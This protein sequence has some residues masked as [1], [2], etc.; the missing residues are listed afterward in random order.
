[1]ENI[2]VTKKIQNPWRDLI[3]SEKILS[4]D[5]EKI[6]SYNEKY[7]GKKER[8][9]STFDFPE[10]FIGTP[11]ADVYVLLANPGRNIKKEEE[12]LKLVKE[13]GLERRILQ[14]LSHD[15]SNNEFPFYFLDP[16]FDE[17]PG[18]KWWQNAFKKL[19]KGDLERRKVIAN[20]FFGIELFGYHSTKCE[21]SL[22]YNSQYRLSSSEYSYHLVLN[23]ITENKIIILARAVGDW[24]SKV[25][26]LREYRNCY[27]LASNRGIQFSNRTIS[28]G[29]YTE[30]EQ[31]I[32][33]RISNISKSDAQQKI[34]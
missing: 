9:V 17:H 27:F 2:I 5:K 18:G 20:E 13:K 4:I 3:N 28:P 19:I 14:N 10:P 24:F 16:D 33:D 32:Q 1:M 26:E 34:Q 29:A 11:E 12:L 22:L 6:E 15:F 8:Q 21:R 23:A 30:I 7:I 25:P 31:I